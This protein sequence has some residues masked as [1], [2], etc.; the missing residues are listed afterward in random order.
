MPLSEEKLQGAVE[1]VRRN[2]G[3]LKIT[4]NID[5][6]KYVKQESFSDFEKLMLDEHLGALI[7]SFKILEA[8]K[9]K[10]G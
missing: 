10:Y 7:T 1:H 3:I 9:K 2:G 5:A 8:Y 4:I 6:N